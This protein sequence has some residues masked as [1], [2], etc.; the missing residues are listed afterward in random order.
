VFTLVITGPDRAQA[1][2]VLEDREVTIGRIEGNH[3]VLADPNVSRRHAR[4]VVR[5]GRYTC[6]PKFGRIT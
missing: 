6:S 5:D 1:R 4:L 2:H 3:I